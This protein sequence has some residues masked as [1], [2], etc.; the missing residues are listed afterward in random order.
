MTREQVVTSLVAYLA[1]DAVLQ[2]DPDTSTA[3]FQA[4]FPDATADELL[5]ATRLHAEWAL[6]RVDGKLQ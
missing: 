2:D 1:S 4:L 5:E 6:A 3:R